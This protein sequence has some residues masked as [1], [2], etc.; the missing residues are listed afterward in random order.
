MAELAVLV[1]WCVLKGSQDFLHTSSIALCHKWDVKNG[2]AY[3]L[4]FFSLISDGLG[5]VY[6]IYREKLIIA[7]FIAF[8]IWL[9][10]LLMNRFCL[11]CLDL[12]GVS[13][14]YRQ[15]H[16]GVSLESLQGFSRV[17]SVYLGGILGALRGLF[18]VPNFLLF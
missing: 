13:S 9:G 8:S 6:E 15:G 12:L 18:G 1:S 3:V 7:I 17:L 10:Y 16:F 11:G 14:G 2:F 5:S 4:Q